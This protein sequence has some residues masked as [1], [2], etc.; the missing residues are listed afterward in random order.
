MTDDSGSI[1]VA[2]EAHLGT[3]EPIIAVPL[4]EF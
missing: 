4:E 1:C 2:Y 3:G